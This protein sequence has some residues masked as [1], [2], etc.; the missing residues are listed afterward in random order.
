MKRCIGNP[1]VLNDG[2]TTIKIK[3]GE[4]EFLEAVDLI[5][6]DITEKYGEKFD[7]IGLIGLARGGLPL[8]VTVS[9]KT[10]IR[11]INVVQIQMTNTDNKWDYGQETW[12]WDHIDED[13]DEFI[14]FE[15]M[16][17]HGRSINLVINELLKRNKKVLA[18]YT[19]FLNSDMKNITLENEYMD[20]VYTN[21]INGNQWVHFFWENGYNEK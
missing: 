19:L 10:G 2:D 3:Y 14:L 6:N 4:K 12:V 9:H 17:S 21:I 11:K 15:D 7:K 13:I 18:V 16:V 5:V 20:I 8:L 1:N